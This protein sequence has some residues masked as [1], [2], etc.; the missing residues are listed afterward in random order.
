MHRAIPKHP[1]PK[2][3]HKSNRA[4]HQQHSTHQREVDAQ[5]TITT[6]RALKLI[7]ASRASIKIVGLTLRWEAIQERAMQL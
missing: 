4:N 5:V 6:R 2:L 3:S 7:T 1:K